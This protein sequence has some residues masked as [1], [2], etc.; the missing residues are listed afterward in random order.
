MFL[1]P[2]GTDRDDGRRP[3]VVPLL[4]VATVAGFIA[5]RPH[6]SSDEDL[7]EA[8]MRLVRYG[9]SY[10]S[11]SWWQPITYQF[12][13]GG[14][15]HLISNMFFLAAFG[16]VLEGRLGRIGRASCRERVFITV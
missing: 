3:V 14:W 13:H 15:F 9:I 10:D 1:I 12:L 5:S 8:L 16:V 11:F 2:T 4:V 6:G 7:L